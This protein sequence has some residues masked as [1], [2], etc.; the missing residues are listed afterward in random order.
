MAADGTAV[1][2]FSYTM[3]T[4]GIFGHTFKLPLSLAQ[5]ISNTSIYSLLASSV[6]VQLLLGEQA[7]CGHKHV[8][9]ASKHTGTVPYTD[10]KKRPHPFSCPF[11][12]MLNL[13]LQLFCKA[14]CL[15]KC[16]MQAQLPKL[17]STDRPSL[18]TPYPG[19]NLT[20]AILFVS[21]LPGQSGS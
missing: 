19:Q 21:S 8:C 12:S 3:A 7:V 9:V 5:S 17:I 2:L 18:L 13:S 11:F 6:P 10:K 16:G 15:K 20:S 14:V 1:R 4:L